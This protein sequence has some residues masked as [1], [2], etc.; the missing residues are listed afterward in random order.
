MGRKGRKGH[1]RREEFVEY[2]SLLW[3][4]SLWSFRS[5]LSLSLSKMLTIKDP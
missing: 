2:I 1:K 3:G 5:F 4:I